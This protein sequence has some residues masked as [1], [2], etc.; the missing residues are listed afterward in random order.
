MEA[1]TSRQKWQNPSTKAG[2]PCGLEEDCKIWS[3]KPKEQTEPSNK[4]IL[5]QWVLVAQV[6]QVM[7]PPNVTGMDRWAARK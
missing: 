6:T 7:P 2:V 4:Y 5:L 1:K 3:K